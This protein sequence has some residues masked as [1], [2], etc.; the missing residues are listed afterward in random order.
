MKSRITPLFAKFIADDVRDHFSESANVYLGIG[1]SLNFGTSSAN[2][3]DVIFTTNKIN[4]LYSN[5][6]GIKK[7]QQADMQVVIAR[8]DWAANIV[9]DAYEDD[10]RLFSFDKF[11]NIG[12]ANANAN[13][14]LT[15]NA[16]IA[17]SNVVVGNGTSF[18]TY[19]FP[20]D[21]L[22]INLAIKTVVS[23]TNNNHLIV[24]SAFA[25]T[26]TGS[27]IVLVNNN[28]TVVANSATFSSS[29]TVGNTI[30]IG[31]DTREV[32]SVRSNKVIS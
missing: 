11:T 17:A 8:R 29:L 9:Y 19:V 20:G 2:V 25:N 26:N 32:V 24:N 13:T 30:V 15:G 5:L 10:V 7:I 14:T 4:E 31:E 28:K 18:L 23:V 6:V 3:D 12:T 21:Q 1:R 22:A 16:N 27:S